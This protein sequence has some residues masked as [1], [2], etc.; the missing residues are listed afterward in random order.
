MVSIRLA[1]GLWQLQ[2]NG[3]R[4]YLPSHL[5]SLRIY[6]VIMMQQW[7][8]LQDLGE[9]EMSSLLSPSL[10]RQLDW[11]DNDAMLRHRDTTPSPTTGLRKNQHQNTYW[12]LLLVTTFQTDNITT[13]PHSQ[14]LHSHQTRQS[15]RRRRHFFLHQNQA[16]QGDHAGQGEC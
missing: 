1:L 7:H 6:C 4:L 9:N 11:D 8:R 5:S 13:P 15:R 16:G 14:C 2:G 12:Q 3:C 10:I